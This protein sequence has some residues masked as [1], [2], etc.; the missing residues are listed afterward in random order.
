LVGVSSPFLLRAP[1]L[2]CLNPARLSGEAPSSSRAGP[3]R[4]QPPSAF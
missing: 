4:A 3:D 2:R 1:D